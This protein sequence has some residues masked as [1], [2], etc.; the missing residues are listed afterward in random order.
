MNRPTWKLL[1]IMRL[2]LMSNEQSRI[3][4]GM[5]SKSSAYTSVSDDD[6]PRHRSRA[7]NAVQGTGDD[8]AVQM[9]AFEL[10]NYRKVNE[11]IKKDKFPLP[12]IDTCLNTLNGCQYYSSCDLRWGYW[13]TEINERDRDKT[14]FVTRKG[15]WRFN[16]RAN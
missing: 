7:V 16:V 4:Q 12:K 6:R 2:R 14:A 8:T 10:W 5:M 1:S 3:T 13:Q 11:L 15:Q 9:S